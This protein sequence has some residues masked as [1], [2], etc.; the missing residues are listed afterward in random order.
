MKKKEHDLTEETKVVL[1]ECLWDYGFFY[2]PYNEYWN[3]V[4]REKISDFF[5]GEL[6]QNEILKNKRINVL[7]EY[8]LRTTE[9]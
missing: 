2:N 3:A 5:N 9:P 8:I 7:V 6:K 1:N 4:K